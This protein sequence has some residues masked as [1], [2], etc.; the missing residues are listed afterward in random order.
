MRKLICEAGLGDSVE[1]ASAGTHGYGVGAAS[2]ARSQRAAQARGY[3]LSQIR[4]RKIGWQDIEDF[5][6]ILAMDKSN[7]DILRRMATAEQQGKINLLMDFARSFFEKEVPDPYTSLGQSFD[8]VLDMIENAA[9][10][11]VAQLPGL[12]RMDASGKL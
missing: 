10:G 9:D 8:H 7:M 12:L 2:D 5:D 11:V 1:V 3:D 6:L 4:A